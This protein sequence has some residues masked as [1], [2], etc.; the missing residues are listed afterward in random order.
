MRADYKIYMF[1]TEVDCTVLYWGEAILMLF[2]FMGR[3]ITPT[4]KLSSQLSL[5]SKISIW[6]YQRF[7]S[8]KIH[9]TSIQL[10]TSYRSV[11]WP[12]FVVV[13]TIFNYWRYEKIRFSSSSSSF[14][15]FKHWFFYCIMI[16]NSSSS[17]LQNS[18]RHYSELH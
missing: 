15:V 7:C 2:F 14:S 12:E 6:K 3:Y 17:I 4:Q 5:R 9:N 11:Y 10:D 13:L 8:S 1:W 16:L 18:F